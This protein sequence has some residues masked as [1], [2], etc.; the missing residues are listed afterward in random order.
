[1]DNQNT[2]N[3]EE[4]TITFWVRKNKINWSDNKIIP[5]FEKSDG[6]SSV[7]ILKDSDNRIKFFHV[8]FGKGRTDVEYDVSGLSSNEQHFFAF[9]WSVKNKNLT[10]YI[11]GKLKVESIIKY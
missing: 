5:L 7:L 1:M 11:D 2:F 3:I 6:G 10:L 8:Y 9:T 4:G